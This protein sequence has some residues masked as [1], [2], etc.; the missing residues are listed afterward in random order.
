MSEKITVNPNIHF[1]KPCV[2]DTRITVQNVLELIGEGISFDKIIQ[3]YY[4]DLR[5]DDLILNLH[6]KNSN[7]S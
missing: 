6:I 3:D 7:E 1:G 5:V 4:P 2:S